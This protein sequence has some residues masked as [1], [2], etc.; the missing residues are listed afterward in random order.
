M[1]LFSAIL[2]T[3]LSI[4]LAVLIAYVLFVF[5]ETLIIVERVG[6]GLAGGSVLLSIAS[7]WAH[8]AMTPYSVWYQWI[9]RAGWILY[10]GGRTYRV[11]RHHSNNQSSKDIAGAWLAARGKR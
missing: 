10:L 5:D 1:I 2:N 8:G 11:R 4:G 3:V 7:I 9:W 6:L